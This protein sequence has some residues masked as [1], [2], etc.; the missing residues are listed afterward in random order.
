METKIKIPRN[1]KECFEIL[2]GICKKED[3]KE[4]KESEVEDTIGKYH[5]SLGMFMRNTFELWGTK[6]TKALSPL[7]KYFSKLGIWHA[8]D[9]SGII[10]TSWHRHL[11]KKPLKV[12]EQ[13]RFY[14]DYWK[15]MNDKQNKH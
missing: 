2:E 4:F 3:I 7:K 15:K 8:D 14:K 6:G 10:M 9:M 13:V 11:N 1:L 5:F 12:L